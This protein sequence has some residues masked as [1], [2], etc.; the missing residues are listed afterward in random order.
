MNGNKVF[1]ISITVLVFLGLTAFTSTGYS[2]ASKI[3]VSINSRYAAAY[4]VTHNKTVYSKNADLKTR[5]ASLAKLLMAITLIDSHSN[6][7][8]RTKTVGADYKYISSVGE[9]SSNYFRSGENAK[10]HDYLCAAMF[11]SA[12]DASM[13][14][15]RYIG[16]GNFSRGMKKINAEAS[17][18][19]MKSTHLADPIGVDNDGT[20]TTC[21]DYTK[22]LKYA[23]KNKTFKSIFCGKS[24]TL[25]TSNYHGKRTIRNSVV[26]AASK[27]KNSLIM[28]GKFGSTAKA[29]RCLASYS[30]FNN[31][32]Y[33]CITTYAFPSKTNNYPQLSD[34]DTI[35]KAIN[36][37]TK[38]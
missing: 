27:R 24:Y 21:N 20:Y 30:K 17:K 14:L 13:T 7:N 4:D 16:N 2:R 1:I 36:K 38:R 34:A 22:L 29:H 9:A 35:Y 12:A 11:I 19:G 26:S 32:E 25:S 18:L 5:P 33:V 31:T 3:N 37:A 28:G 10:L 8:V 23:I 15:A 6:L